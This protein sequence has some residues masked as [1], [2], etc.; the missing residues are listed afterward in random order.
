MAKQFPSVPMP[1]RA[2]VADDDPFMREL[3]AS[4]LEELG[5]ETVTARSGADALGRLAN[6]RTIDLLVADINM[7]G[8]SGTEVAERARSFRPGIR[9]LLISGR[10]SDGRGFPLL[11]KP[12]SRSDLRRVMADGTGLCDE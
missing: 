1:R 12:F 11:Q 10:E 3:V 7:P 8:M 6:E 9:I 4:M 2:L 5:C